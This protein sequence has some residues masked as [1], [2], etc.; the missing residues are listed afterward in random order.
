M[1]VLRSLRFGDVCDDGGGNSLGMD[2]CMI[3]GHKPSPSHCLL[4]DGCCSVCG[5][6]HALLASTLRDLL[7]NV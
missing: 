7:P 3:V 2:G 4:V 1:I 6:H 5:S